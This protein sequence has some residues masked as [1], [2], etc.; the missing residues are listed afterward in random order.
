[1][2]SLERLA[3]RQQVTL[4]VTQPDKPQ[5]RGLKLEPSPV[6]VAA[7]RLGVPLRQLERLDR[8]VVEESGVELGVAVAYGMLIPRE[9]LAAPRHGLLGVHPS[10]LPKYRGAAPVAWAIL[11][12]ETMTGVTVFR[13]NE[14]LDAGE[15]LVQETVRI[16]P[17]EDAQ[18]LAE[19]LAHLGADAL[20]RAVD[21]I[22]TG[23]VAFRPQDDTAAIMAPKLTKAQGRV[24][25]AA[26]AETLARLIRALVPW[27]GATTEWHGQSVKL[28]AAS[29][30]AGPAAAPGTV[31]SVGPEAI[32]VATGQ[33]LLAIRALQPAGRRR[34]AVQEFLAGH[35]VNVGDRFE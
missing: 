28:W 18:A 20:M 34:M 19:R 8:A 15:I 3:A 4:C 16:E 31:V 6:K 5:G 13:L 2:P 21:M 35:H 23:R 27:P 12:G 26:P 11:N 24:E 25:W 22:D 1:M 14:R 9:V 7:R 33:G 32:V 30:T 29:A 17:E 10:L